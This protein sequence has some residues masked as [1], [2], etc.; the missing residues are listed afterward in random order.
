ME[1]KIIPYTDKYASIF[2]D[3]NLAWLEKY[4]Y[5]EDHDKEVLENA[6][7]YIVGN[8]GFIFFA[9][10]NN[11]VAG[12]VAL[13]NEKEGF[14]LSKMAVDPNF[15]GQKIGQQLLQHCITFAKQKSWDK[16]VIYSSTILE[17]A[18]Y[19]Y[20][21][22]GFKEVELEKDSPYQRSDIKMVLEL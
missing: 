20:R 8:G 17:N 6:K 4:F 11:K 13:I 12:T 10:V 9:L 22:Y 3:L 7:E 2:R 21:K 5:V 1:V 14:E 19:I 18:I 16:L 15:Q